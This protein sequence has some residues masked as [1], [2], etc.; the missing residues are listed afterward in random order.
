[1]SKTMLPNQQT[2]PSSDQIR[3]GY[4]PPHEREI[5]LEKMADGITEL[6]AHLDAGSLSISTPTSRHSNRTVPASKQKWKTAAT[7]LRKRH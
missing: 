4:Y 5:K 7:F 1:M 3:A 6:V 2:A